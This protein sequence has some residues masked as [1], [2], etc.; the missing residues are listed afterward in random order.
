MKSW[1][2]GFKS[3]NKLQAVGASYG[4]RHV[5]LG[6]LTTPPATSQHFK[7]HCPTSISNPAY[8]PLSGISQET[9]ASFLTGTVCAGGRNPCSSAGTCSCAKQVQ[10]AS[11]E[12]TKPTAGQPCC[13]QQ[14]AA[15][16]HSNLGF[17]AEFLVTKAKNIS[18][19]SG[20]AA[21][22]AQDQARCQ[23]EREAALARL[24]AE[25]TLAAGIAWG[26]AWW[27]THPPWERWPRV[28]ILHVCKEIRAI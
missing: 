4:W 11:L 20:C 21:S 28:W 2:R 26:A 24:L 25:P 22:A 14:T 17:Y 13:C 12:L 15:T 10:T 8:T 23:Q 7:L 19:L 18:H 6:C 1:V 27:N 16:F 3:G 9:L 5:L